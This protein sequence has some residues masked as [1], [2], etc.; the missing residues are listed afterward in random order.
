VTR[1]IG[2]IHGAWVTADCWDRFVPYFE[3]KG[4]RCLAPSWPGKER[5]VEAIRAD[6]SPLAGLGIGEIVDHYAGIIRG[7]DEPPILIG[8]S[9]GGLF[10]Q[11]LLDRGLGLAGVAIDSAPPRGIWAYEPTALRSLL[12]TLLHWR[13]W[14]KVV[15]WKYSNFRYAFVHTLP[16]EEARAAYDRYVVPETGRIFFQS[17]IAMLDPSSPTRVDFAN[18]TRAPLLLIAG[19]KDRV[20]PAVI[21]RRNHR[22]YAKS[23]ARTDLREFPDRTHWIIAQDGWREVAEYAADWL[24]GQGLGPG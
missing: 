1:T 16:E 17:A 12:T 21:N 11:L 20:V 10:T 5:T 7:L 9:F 14:R 3:G 2:F 13:V 24:E 22:A 23:G 6:P 15:R 19:A 8:H 4:Y 18:A